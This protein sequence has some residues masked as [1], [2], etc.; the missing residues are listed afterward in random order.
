MLIHQDCLIALK[1]LPND[2]V[3]LICTDPPYGY[4]FMGSTWDV[5]VPSL[6]IWKECLRVL[7]PGG[8]CFAMSAPRQDVLTKMVGRLS[9]AGFVTSFTSIY[10]TYANGFPK[11]L[12]IGK[13]VDK[14]LGKKRKEI[15]HNPNHR[16]SDAL[17]K[18]GFQGG[19]G[20][21][22]LTEGDSPFEGAYAG[23]QPK[24]AVEVI[25]VAMKPLSERTYVDQAL[26]NGKGVTWL[27][28]ARI[29]VAEGD[30]PKGG[31]GVEVTG[32]GPFDNKKGAKWTESPTK[33]MGR[34]PANLLVSDALFD[35][36]GRF[37]DLDAWAQRTFPFLAVPKASKGEKDKGLENW[38]EKR[39]VSMATANGTSGKPSSITEG[40]NTSRAN[41][42]PTIKPLTLM[43]YLV[44]IGSRP[45]DTVLDPF[46]G[47]GTTCIAAKLLGRKFIGMEKDKSYTAIARARVRAARSPGINRSPRRAYRVRRGESGRAYGPR[48]GPRRSRLRVEE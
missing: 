10:W 32:L 30:E 40:R 12:H 28:D 31:Y 46:M 6:E 23:F 13:A 37:F 11:A 42:H 47:S 44:T 26:T 35:K 34:F 17:Y 18:L 15:G 39:I 22:K 9:E 8:F 5:D 7:K 33:G 24:P 21:G 2:S 38:K 19:R 29:P 43:T 1:K 48:R 20:N 27:D 3:D 45:G 4:R 25:V 36:F 16:T 41:H 14:R